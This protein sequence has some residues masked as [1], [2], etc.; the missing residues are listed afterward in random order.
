MFEALML[1]SFIGVPVYYIHCA[2]VAKR[3]QPMAVRV[4]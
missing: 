3:P 1:L 4:K 2:I